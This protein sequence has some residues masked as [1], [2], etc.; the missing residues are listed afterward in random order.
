MKLEDQISSLEQAIKLKELGIVQQS[1]AFWCLHTDKPFPVNRE[2]VEQS[3]SL[4]V[5]TPPRKQPIAAFTAAELVHML[6]NLGN[7][8]MSISDKKQ[9]F[10]TKT[11]YR[12]NTPHHLRFWYFDSFAQAC[13]AKLIRAIENEYETIEVFNKR[14]TA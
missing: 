13:A 8:E 9:W 5:Y 6:Q 10:S 2:F 12:K 3:S 4:W 11:D 14:L 1:E 7:I